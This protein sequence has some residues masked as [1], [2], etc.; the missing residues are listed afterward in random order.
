MTP[1]AGEPCGR[2]GW[3]AVALAAGTQRIAHNKS[4]AWQPARLFLLVHQ[5]QRGSSI[6]LARGPA[7]LTE[8]VIKIM[9]H[10]LARQ[11]RV[12]GEASPVAVA[13]GKCCVGPSGLEIR[14]ESRAGSGVF[15]VRSP[16]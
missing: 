4:L 3:L 5:H 2:T 10:P 9:K 7:S 12:V 6:G 14:L 11:R 8:L 13:T 1:G 16:R 15:A